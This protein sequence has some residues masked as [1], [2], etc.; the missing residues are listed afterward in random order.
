MKAST[1]AHSASHVILSDAKNLVL[2]RV[3]TVGA[4][5]EPPYLLI[6][7]PAQARIHRT[8]CERYKRGLGFHRSDERHPG[9]PDQVGQ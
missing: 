3:T 5:R 7:I 1:S 8:L 2:H 6:V 9:L 4:V